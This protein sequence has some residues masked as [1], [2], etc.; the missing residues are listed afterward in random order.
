MLVRNSRPP[1]LDK[2]YFVQPTAFDQVDPES[3][4]AREENRPSQRA[5]I[6]LIASKIGCLV[7][8]L[9]KCVRRAERG[10]VKAEACF[11]C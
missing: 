5:A 9:R 4:I 7:E 11:Q 6:Q 2:S 10:E 8:T 3:R 1:G